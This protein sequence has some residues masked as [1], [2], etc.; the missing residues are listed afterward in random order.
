M[1]LF[2]TAIHPPLHQETS[3]LSFLKII[4]FDYVFKKSTGALKL[5]IEG[6]EEVT[7]ET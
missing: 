3:S 4:Q 5:L 2:A 1:D 6:Q 7:Y